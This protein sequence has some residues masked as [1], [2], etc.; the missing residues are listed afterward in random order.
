[1]RNLL[2]ALLFL[3]LAAAA[4]DQPFEAVVSGH[5]T[6]GC[7][8]IPIIDSRIQWFTPDRVESSPTIG[9]I[10]TGDHE[11]VFAII[12]QNPP[13]VR[14]MQVEPDGTRTPFFEGLPGA[15][16]SAI[17]VAPSGRVVVTYGSPVNVAVIS[18]GGALEATYA[19]PGAL[20]FPAI[21]IGPDNCT[22]YYTKAGSV[23]RF[24]VCTG[25]ALP[26]FIAGSFLDIEA[27]PNGQV[28]LSSGDQVFLY[29]AGATL[30]RE[31][32]ELSDYGF[33]NEVLAEQIALDPEGVT[34]YVTANAGCDAEPNRLL[35]ISFAAG[36]LLSNRQL[37][38]N[39]PSSL[40]VGTLEGLSDVPAAG[41]AA[42]GFLA[43]TL[44]FAA[45]WLL[46]R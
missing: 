45:I 31:V 12:Q 34:L 14:V 5:Q 38:I 40:V 21:A 11:R 35:T 2:I 10:A 37:E 26:D 39:R 7:L 18:A 28:L 46:R 27:L 42:L 15:F 6:F 1:M 9:P 22:L 36:E 32:A 43:I 24:D 19:L 25:T 17:A 44:A 8:I 29:D 23:G 30:I 3:P 4:Q 13:S 20:Q 16:A 41:T 33:A